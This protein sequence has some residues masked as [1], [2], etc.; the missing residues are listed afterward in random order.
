MGPKV[1]HQKLTPEPLEDRDK[2]N[3]KNWTIPFQI[4]ERPLA[5]GAGGSLSEKQTWEGKGGR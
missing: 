2:S 4:T 5:I 3:A 1:T